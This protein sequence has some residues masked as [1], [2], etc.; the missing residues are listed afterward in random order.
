MSLAEDFGQRLGCTSRK[1]EGITIA[2]QVSFYSNRLADIACI[3]FFFKCKSC[4]GSNLKA[5]LFLG[6]YEKNTNGVR[7]C[8]MYTQNASSRSI[9]C[10]YI[11]T[12]DNLSR[13]PTLSRYPF[14][15]LYPG[16]VH[17]AHSCMNQ[18]PYGFQR[19]RPFNLIY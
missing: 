9:V 11:P 18:A 6:A 10:A 13:I 19:T 14:P 17:Q 8:A 1:T 4:S 2:R 3:G 5:P 7:F 12:N 15:P 16:I